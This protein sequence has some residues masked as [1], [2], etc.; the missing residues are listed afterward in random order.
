MIPKYPEVESLLSDQ[1]VH[2]MLNA[3]ALVVRSAGCVEAGDS[4]SDPRVPVSLAR[5]IEP[6]ENRHLK[7]SKT[8]RK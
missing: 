8:R 1:L 2:H 4:V 7:S 5:S 3:L 6:G